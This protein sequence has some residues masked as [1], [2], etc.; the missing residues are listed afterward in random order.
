M[1][2]GGG[3]KTKKVRGVGKRL[4]VSKR[5]KEEAVKKI[6]CVGNGTREK[7]AKYEGCVLT[8]KKTNQQKKKTNH[9]KNTKQPNNTPKQ[10]T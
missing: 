7:A 8:P 1:K 9:K 6:D 3:Q 2:G 10:N 5:K 4:H